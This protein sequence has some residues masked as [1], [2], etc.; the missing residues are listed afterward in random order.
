MIIIVLS[1]RAL[2]TQV[3]GTPTEENRQRKQT[4]HK[5]NNAKMQKIHQK[6]V[7]YR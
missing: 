4:I 7:I 3:E 6:N 5:R 2:A 1:K